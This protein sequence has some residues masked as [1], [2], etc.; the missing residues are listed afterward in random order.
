MSLLPAYF[1]NNGKSNTKKVSSSAVAEHEAW[2]IKN[3]VHP[4][5]IKSR[6]KTKGNRADVKFSV[7]V[8]RIEKP[9]L[10]GIGPTGL[11]RNEN[12][13]TGR[14]IIGVAVLHKS[15]MQPIRTKEAASDIARMRRG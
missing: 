7:P 5:Q 14:E 2:L 13:Y 6:T 15:C 3:G 8:S 9:D 10:S 1:N 12:K 11:K 4:S